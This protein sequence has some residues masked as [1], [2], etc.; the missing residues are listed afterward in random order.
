MKIRIHRLHPDVELPQYQTPGSA[1]FDLAA[2]AS[3]TIAPGEAVEWVVLDARGRPRG[4]LELPA[5]VRILWSRDDIVWAVVPD[6]NDVQWL[7]RYRI[8]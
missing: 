7:V 2:S 8:R 6:E 5:N 1:A 3:V 4:R